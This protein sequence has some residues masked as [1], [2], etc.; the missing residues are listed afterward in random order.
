MSLHFILDGYNII[1]STPEFS[2]N[3][4]K[5]SRQM[6]LK[7]IEIYRPQGSVKNKV[8]I[9]FDGKSSITSPRHCVNAK[10][11]F[12]QDC[13][14]DEEIKRMVEEAPNPK[15]IVVVS[16]DR[17]IQLFIKAAGAKVMSVKDF[18][19]KIKKKIRSSQATPK[20]EISAKEASAITQELK[21]IWL[22]ETRRD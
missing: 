16:D 14:A 1:K 10:F 18:L 20:F 19:D 4:I 7:F 9:V 3:D 2:S 8:S 15:Q 22:K 6:L 5:D 17:D 21:T 12:T 13:S 11:L